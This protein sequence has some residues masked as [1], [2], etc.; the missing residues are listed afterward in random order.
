M[1]INEKDCIQGLNKREPEDGGKENIGL[2]VMGSL[3]NAI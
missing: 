3:T 1:D 2:G